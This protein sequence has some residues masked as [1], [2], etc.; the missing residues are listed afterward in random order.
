MRHKGY[1]SKIMV[2]LLIMSLIFIISSCRQD[3]GSAEAEYP[4]PRDLYIEGFIGSGEDRAVNLA[5]ETPD[6][7]YNFINYAVY[8][9]NVGGYLDI[10]LENEEET[11]L[12]LLYKNAE[13]ITRT[14]D[15]NY[16]HIIGNKNYCFYVT[17]VYDGDIESKPSNF[18]CPDVGT[19][20]PVRP[21]T[22]EDGGN[23]NGEDLNGD[24]KKESEND[25]LGRDTS[26]LCFSPY[27]PVTYGA[28]YT[29]Q[30]TGT[31]SWIQT[32]TI[33][34]VYAEGFTEEVV[35]DFATHT[36]EWKCLPEGL[37]NTYG[38]TM[39]TDNDS[40]ATSS[41][42]DGITVPAS[43]SV[44][45]IWTQT[46]DLVSS[47]GKG[48]GELHRSVTF[49]RTAAA[50]EEVTVPAGTFEAIRVDYDLEMSATLVTHDGHSLPLF[51]DYTSG[52]EWFVEDIGL[53]KKTAGVDIDK[54]DTP[55]GPSVQ[56]SIEAS[57]VHELIEYSLPWD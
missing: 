26:G 51:V 21:G 31:N 52:S 14:T 28:S 56:L 46:C 47:D 19:Y 33:T 16:K 53:V 3:K 37:V 54:M 27:Y 49:N 35:Q 13:E 48:E 12:D 11:N 7:E 24:H 50:I 36:Y 20:D 41:D 18:L 57:G 4:P 5:W 15:T 34:E 25:T 23:G 8:R 2:M 22:G 29:Y 45:D 32:H 38:G 17:A 30:V 9:F 1:L 40:V 6:T 39:V 10:E 55:E 43:I 44:G 42:V